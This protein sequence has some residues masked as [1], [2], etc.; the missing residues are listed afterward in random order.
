MQTM[1][2]LAR[3][4]RECEG[5]TGSTVRDGR[6]T[7]LPEQPQRAVQM[8]YRGGKYS[9]TSSEDDVSV[10]LEELKP[11]RR[12]GFGFCR[13]GRF[14]VFGLCAAVTLVTLYL[15]GFELITRFHLS[16]GLTQFQK[17]VGEVCVIRYTRY[18]S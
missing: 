14:L 9:G 2:N 15:I 7:W 16:R 4:L 13:V 5:R 17:V 3:R 8:Q 18:S 12:P 10:I 6:A 11:R 1:Q